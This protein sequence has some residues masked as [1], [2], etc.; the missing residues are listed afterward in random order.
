MSEAKK[1]TH[2]VHFKGKFTHYRDG[3]QHLS[4]ELICHRETYASIQHEQNTFHLRNMLDSV[5]QLKSNDR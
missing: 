1:K 3:R 2:T 4:L 5:K